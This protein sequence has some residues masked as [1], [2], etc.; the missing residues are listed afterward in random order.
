MILRELSKSSSIE[1]FGSGYAVL[2]IS[3]WFQPAGI[4][5]PGGNSRQ[6]VKVIRLQ[7]KVERDQ[8]LRVPDYPT[9]IALVF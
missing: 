4:F 6:K 1:K 7:G 8:V 2:A 5:Q 9:I 3:G